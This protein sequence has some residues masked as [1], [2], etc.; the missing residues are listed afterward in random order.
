MSIRFRNPWVDPRVLTLSPSKVRAY[1]ERHGWQEADSAI[2][3]TQRFLSPLQ[4]Q[5][6]L[7]VLVPATTD[8][9]ALVNLLVECVGKVAGWEERYAGDLLDDLLGR[10]VAP[11]TNGAPNPHPAGAP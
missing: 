3:G 4:D 9:D 11:P 1:L 8:D 2:P 7:A 6:R 5:N 10:T